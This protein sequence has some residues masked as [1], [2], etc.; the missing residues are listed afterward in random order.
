MPPASGGA[1]GGEEIAGLDHTLTPKQDQSR[2]ADDRHGQDAA[3]IV[4]EAKTR[5][6]PGGECVVDVADCPQEDQPDERPGDDSG[7]AD[8]LGEGGGVD[9][10]KGT[11]AHSVAHSP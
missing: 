2:G 4:G 8:V 10:G 7:V 11:L 3:D 5:V 6:K 9:P 1:L